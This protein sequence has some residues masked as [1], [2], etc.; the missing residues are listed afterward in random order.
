MHHECAPFMVR[1][2][3]QYRHAAWNVVV[4]VLLQR[5]STADHAQQQEQSWPAAHGMLLSNTY[6][7][8]LCKKALGL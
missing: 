7:G 5:T 8:K 1:F 6:V 3:N 2:T 4:L